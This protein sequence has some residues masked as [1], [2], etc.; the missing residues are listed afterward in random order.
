M[1]KKKQIA[2]YVATKTTKF[3]PIDIVSEIGCSMIYAQNTLKELVHKGMLTTEKDG[4]TVYY[5]FAGAEN[6]DTFQAIDLSQMVSVHER[7]EFITHFVNMVIDGINPSCLIVG[8]S[9]VGKT[10]LVNETLKDAGLKES[11]DYVFVKGH[12]S[13]MGLY[14]TLHNYRDDIIIFDDCDSVFKETTSTNLLKGALDSYATRKISWYSKAVQQAGLDESFEFTGKIIFISNLAQ[15]QID[16]A[17]RSRTFVIDIQLS[18]KELIERIEE[19][20]DY[21]EPNIDNDIKM[22]VIEHLHENINIFTQFNIRTFIKALRIR[23]GCANHDWRKMVNI[24]A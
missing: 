13:P 24:M 6:E 2:D 4:R 14:E 22:E 18:K 5:N 16:S 17:V 23:I 1:N 15:D 11:C 12:S 19:I 3:H 20:K 9:G 8:A 21:I 7:F 10:H